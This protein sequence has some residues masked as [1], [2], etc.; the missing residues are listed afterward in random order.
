MRQRNGPVMRGDGVEVAV[1]DGDE[2]V[3]RQ[4]LCLRHDAIGRRV[5]DQVFGIQQVRRRA[6][7]LSRSVQPRI[8]RTREVPFCFR[9]LAILDTQS[10]RRQRDAIA[11]FDEPVITRLPAD[12]VEIPALHFPEAGHGLPDA[13]A[14]RD[15]DGVLS[16]AEADDERRGFGIVFDDGREVLI[17]QRP[18]ARAVAVGLG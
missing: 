14:W 3:A 2:L 10:H 6:A 8:V 16:L 4:T 7:R 18:Q 12:V 13:A 9:E 17:E 11:F 15:V 5:R 1:D